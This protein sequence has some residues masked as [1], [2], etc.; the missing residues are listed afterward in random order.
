[1]T[2]RSMPNT[3]A[4][5][6]SFTGSGRRG[7]PG[8][9]RATFIVILALWVALPL[10]IRHSNSVDATAYVAAVQQV[11]KDPDALYAD[12]VDT[13]SDITPEY[14]QTWCAVA[15]VGTSRDCVASAFL[16][17]PLA[18]PV[19]WVLSLGG[20]PIGIYVFQFLSAAALVASMLLI[21]Q[22]LAGRAR[23]APAAIVGTAVVL[24]PLALKTVA[25]GQTSPWLFLSVCLGIGSV[26]RARR[27]TSTV[28]W[29]GAVVFKST[30]A[31]LAAVLAWRRQFAVLARA[32]VALV[33]LALLSLAFAPLDSWSR[34]LTMSRHLSHVAGGI[35]HNFSIAALTSSIWG[36]GFASRHAT[37]VQ[38]VGL[39]AA[40][41]FCVTTMRRVSDDVAWALAAVALLLVAPLVWSH[42]LWA[43]IGATA[44]VTAA[45]RGHVDQ[46]LWVLPVVAFALSAPV[47]F[48]AETVFSNVVISLP[49]SQRFWDLYRPLALLASLGVLAGVTISGRRAEGRG[50][51]DTKSPGDHPVE[52]EASVSPSG[53]PSHSAI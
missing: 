17:S 7:R 25:L 4:D 34:Y 6:A 26:D 15:Q 43:V 51:A 36:P 18:L 44:V 30:P 9:L 28:S 16:S 42:Y 50:R 32:I 38:L 47:T 11:R 41:A 46:V 12:R 13:W 5:Q 27:G 1:M 33:A 8:P 48:G 39:G 24:T 53:L 22:L 23:H 20:R 19:A 14:R 21:W 10:A 3:P 40:V 45:R 35:P 29:L 2:P 37:E 31:A 52:S 49:L